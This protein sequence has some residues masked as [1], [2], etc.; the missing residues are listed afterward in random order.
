[1]P[2]GQG[3]SIDGHISRWC[4]LGRRRLL[5]IKEA[6]QGVERM[7]VDSERPSCGEPHSIIIVGKSHGVDRLR[8]GYVIEW[9]TSSSVGTHPSTLLSDLGVAA[10]VMKIS[11]LK[12]LLVFEKIEDFRIALG[13]DRSWWVDNGF[14]MLPW[15]EELI[16]KPRREV[17]LNCYGVPLQARCPRTFLS[18][19]HL[20][21]SHSSLW[22]RG[23]PSTVRLWKR[24]Q[25]SCSRFREVF[26]LLD[27]LDL[28]N[29]GRR[30]G[31]TVG[32]LRQP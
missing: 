5:F 15:S 26:F 30:S 10:R 22:L 1:M 24:L 28:E 16:L 31:A 3:G 4:Q 21:P 13:L 7:V 2:H 17:W 8:C 18:I 14:T 12:W 23:S 6:L 25:S 27:Q 32:R 11:R 29:H 20:S 19:G 9:M